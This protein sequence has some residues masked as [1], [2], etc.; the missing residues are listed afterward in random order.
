[1]F[2]KCMFGYLCPHGLLA[3]ECL[4]C[5]QSDKHETNCSR[6]RLG[7]IDVPDERADVL[8]VRQHVS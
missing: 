5:C 3:L 2:Y 1:M 4:V 8:S 6:L 7:K